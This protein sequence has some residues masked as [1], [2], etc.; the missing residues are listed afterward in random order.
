MKSNGESNVPL[1]VLLYGNTGWFH[2]VEFGYDHGGR[3]T[4]DDIMMS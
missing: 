1:Q 3:I 2:G 4:T